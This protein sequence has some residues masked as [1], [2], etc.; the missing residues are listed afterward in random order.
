MLTGSYPTQKLLREREREE[1][2]M[3]NNKKSACAIEE[4]V[5]CSTCII[6]DQTETNSQLLTAGDFWQ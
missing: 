3:T 5:C 1:K 6:K 2:N 4:Q